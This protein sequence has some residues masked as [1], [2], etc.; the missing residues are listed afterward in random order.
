MCDRQAARR[1]EPACRTPGRECRRFRPQSG[2]QVFGAD[3]AAT[4]K[5]ILAHDRPKANI[6]GQVE[7]V[8]LFHIPIQRHQIIGQSGFVAE[9]GVRHNPDQGS[10]P[11]KRSAEAKVTSEVLVE[12][13]HG[14]EVTLSCQPENPKAVA[15][16]ATGDRVQKR[17]ADDPAA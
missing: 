16:A 10:G 17:R 7:Q 5:A 14:F 6:D 13:E 4:A 1:R 11:S 2:G 15:G 12:S 3:P 9:D 8:D